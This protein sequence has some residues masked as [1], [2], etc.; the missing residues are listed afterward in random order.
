M[1]SKRYKVCKP[2]NQFLSDL[3]D[4]LHTEVLLNEPPDVEEIFAHCS[5][6]RH[7]RREGPRTANF[8]NAHT[9]KDV[10]LMSKNELA[11]DMEELVL[12]NRDSQ[13]FPQVS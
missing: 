2:L 5:A 3:T 9:V 10:I 6:M 13:K 11:K 12:K 4:D 8:E 7:N 1:P